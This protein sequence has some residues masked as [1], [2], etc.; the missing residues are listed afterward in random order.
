VWAVPLVLALWV[1]CHGSF[2]VG[3]GVLALFALGAAIE[4]F[5]EAA[6]IEDG[7]TYIEPPLWYYP[8]RHSLGKA[9][10]AAGRTKEA[11]QAYEQDLRRFPEN[12]WSLFG[13]EQ[14]L[15]AQQRGA[16]ADR[17]KERLSRAWQSA[18]VQLTA[19]RF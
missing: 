14:S 12:G 6:A 17:V 2:V 9:L 10:L 5:R 15:R 13:L 3:V 11:E 1:N 18:D 19:S 4:A 16:D 7:L 8:V